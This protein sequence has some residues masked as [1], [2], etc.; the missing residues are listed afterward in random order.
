MSIHFSKEDIQKAS[1]K[2]RLNLI[3][4][5]S[6]VK[7][8][9]L[10]GTVSKTNGNNLAIISSVVHLGSAPA[11]LGFI[12][13]PNQEVRRD[14]LNNIEE[15]G[16]F[17]I[18]HIQ[19]NMVKRAHYTSTKFPSEISEFDACGLGAE[20]LH[21]FP[22]PFVSES[23]VKIGLKHVETVII[24]ANQTMMIVGEIQDI[25]LPR[26]SIDK[27]GYLKLCNMHTV[28]IGGLNSYYAL[29]KIAEH[30]Y[31]RLSEIPNLKKEV[32]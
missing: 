20:F 6:G 2:F 21:D 4:S 16:C 10:V 30:P 1:S 31:A 26:E 25:Y 8:A 9:N 23:I 24:Q 28:G 18:N 11:L 5:I 12:M 17:T 3:N 22:A 27:R 15:N 19:K 13:R 7:P 32:L 14:T 29:K